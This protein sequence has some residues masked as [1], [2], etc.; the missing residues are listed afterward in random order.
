M[1]AARLVARKS[2]SARLLV[3]QTTHLIQS[4]AIIRLALAHANAKFCPTRDL[5]HTAGFSPT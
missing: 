2:V 4:L 5:R 1:S 3:R